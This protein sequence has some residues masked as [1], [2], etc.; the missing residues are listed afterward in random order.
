MNQRR[1]LTDVSDVPAAKVSKLFYLACSG[2]GSVIGKIACTVC[3]TRGFVHLSSEREHDVSIDM[4]CFFCKDCINCKG[5]GVQD[6]LQ[7]QFETARNSIF[8]IE[9]TR[10]SVLPAEQS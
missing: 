1:D 10:H 7:S 3:E 5:S 8:P 4:R 9:N 2:S 6:G